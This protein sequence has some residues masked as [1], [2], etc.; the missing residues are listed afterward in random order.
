MT[1]MM[2]TSRVAIG[3]DTAMPNGRN[4]AIKAFIAFNQPQA[5]FTSNKIGE[6]QVRKLQVLL[7]YK[8]ARCLGR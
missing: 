2:P 6:F 5:M 3:A 7:C 1:C 8:R 4:R